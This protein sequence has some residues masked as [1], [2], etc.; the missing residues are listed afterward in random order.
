MSADS[1]AVL[2]ADSS[3]PQRVR[4]A[5]IAEIAKAIWQAASRP[6]VM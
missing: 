6:L 1:I 3:E 5:V 4:E 2:V